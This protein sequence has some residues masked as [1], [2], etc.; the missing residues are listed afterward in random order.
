MLRS[1]AHGPPDGSFNQPL[2]LPGLL[3]N[4]CEHETLEFGINRIDLDSARHTCCQLI[5]IT[6]EFV[7][8]KTECRISMLFRGWKNVVQHSRNQMEI[9]TYTTGS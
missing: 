3:V 7:T 4:L 1:P 8:I 6:E 5:S 2:H 9:H